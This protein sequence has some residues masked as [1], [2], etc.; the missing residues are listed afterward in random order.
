MQGYV[1]PSIKASVFNIKFLIFLLIAGLT[2]TFFYL[3]QSMNQDKKLQQVSVQEEAM[4]LLQDARQDLDAKLVEINQ[5]RGRF[6]TNPEGPENPGTLQELIVSWAVEMRTRVAKKTANPKDKWHNHAPWRI[7]ES[8]R[9]NAMAQIVAAETG[10]QATLKY[11]DPRTGKSVEIL[12][13]S[14]GLMLL[15]T[16][17]L[18]AINAAEYNGRISKAS[19]KDVRSDIATEELG[20]KIKSAVVSEREGMPEVAAAKLSTDIYGNKIRPEQSVY[21]DQA[22]KKLEKIK[23]HLNVVTGSPH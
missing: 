3:V 12:L 9:E 1:I 4:L 10:Q 14:E 2:V 23:E 18:I 19:L 16:S 5:E 22:E 13:D 6:D 15:G 11:V 8:M 7:Y 20:R 21:K 17:R